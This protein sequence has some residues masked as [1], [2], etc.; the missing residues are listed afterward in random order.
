ML[1]TINILVNMVTSN[2]DCDTFIP[3]VLLPVATDF[4]V[5]WCFYLQV[6]SNFGGKGLFEEYIPLLDDRRI[7]RNRGPQSTA[8][9]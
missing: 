1:E 3:V 4:G 2:F 7:D 5:Q 6:G 9:P 8:P